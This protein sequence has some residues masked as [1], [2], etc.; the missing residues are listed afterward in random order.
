MKLDFRQGI[1]RV[2]NVLG[3]PS[4][5]TYNSLANT[6]DINITTTKLLITLAHREENF[7]IEQPVSDNELWGP[8]I[9]N[10]DWGAEPALGLINYYMYWDIDLSSGL[11]TYGF[12]PRDFITASVAP[13]TLIDQHWYDTNENVMRVWNGQFW[14][15]RCRLF[16]G[17]FAPSSQTIVH[18]PYGS[19]V[20][21]DESILAGYVIFGNDQRALKLSDGTLATSVTEVKIK[22]GGYSSPVQLEGL[23][24]TMLAA[25]PLYAFSAV[26][27]S[28]LGEIV[29]ANPGTTAR[30]IGLIKDDTPQGS[31]VTVITEG[32]IFCEQW[33]WELDYGHDLMLGPNGTL[34]QGTTGDEGVQRI[35]TILTAQTAFLCIND[36]FASGGGNLTLENDVDVIGT[37]VGAIDEGF[38]FLEGL[39][40]TQFVTLVS[41]RTLP[42]AYGVPTLSLGSVP[43]PTTTEVGTILSPLLSISYSQN[44]GGATSATRLKKN[45]STISPSFPYTDSTIQLTLATITYVA[46]LDYDQGP[47]LNDNMGMPDP[48]GRIN[49]G[50]AVSNQ[51]IFLGKRQ[52]FYGSPASTPGS[53]AAIRALTSSFNS[54]NNSGVDA[55]GVSIVSAPTPNFVITIPIG[56]TRVVFAYPADRRAVASVKYQELS[57]SEVKANFTETSVMVEGANAY[58][59][60]AYRVFTYIPVEPFSITN[61]YKVFI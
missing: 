28:D 57:D 12:T 20:G 59:P 6:L 5:L 26:A 46:E 56:A 39:T 54:D 30:A 29:L 31:P 24:T 15:E 52:A 8:L 14:I 3:Q 32:V 23:S 35:A 44:N 55:A 36:V 42:P 33:N 11:V 47:I 10:S 48:T 45:G 43:S 60:V 21:I 61:H 18:K 58:S 4:F 38:T 1:V 17:S 51:I 7:L 50:T 37:S 34:V 22:Q 9:W 19:Q 53:S 27:V 41:Q 16:A 49:A 25:E 13:P 2:R 40:F